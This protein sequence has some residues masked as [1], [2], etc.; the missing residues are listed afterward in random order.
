MLQIIPKVSFNYEKIIIRGYRCKTLTPAMREML[1]L[2]SQSVVDLTLDGCEF[3]LVALCEFLRELPLLNSLKLNV[4]ITMERIFDIPEE[5]LPNLLQLKDFDESESE[6]GSKIALDNQVLSLF[7]EI[8]MIYKDAQSDE[9]ECHSNYIPVTKEITKSVDSNESHFVDNVIET[10]SRSVRSKNEINIY[11]RRNTLS[12]KD[13][14]DDID[15]DSNKDSNV[16]SNDDSDDD[17]DDGSD[18]LMALRIVMWIVMRIAMSIVMTIVITI[19]MTIAM[20]VVMG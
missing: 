7:H 16:D 1:K 3:D 11:Q 8:L 5:C 12:E 10:V 18:G 20:T 17:S 14:Y 9:V 4:F 19:V 6:S 15:D 13:G 2:L